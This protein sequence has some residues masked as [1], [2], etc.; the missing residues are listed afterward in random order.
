MSILIQGFER[1]CKCFCLFSCT[2]A[3]ALRKT[4][5]GPPTSPGEERET[6]E[7]GHFQQV[8]PRSV[9]PQLTVMTEPNREQQNHP[10]EPI[11]ESL[12]H[13]KQYILVFSH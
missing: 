11:L 7:Q 10:A 1:L 5:L 12:T 2:H 3:I 6:L 9:D 13:D 4:C 8:H